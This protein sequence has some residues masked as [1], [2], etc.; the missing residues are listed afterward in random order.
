MS[1]EELIA[2]GK[3]LAG[4][5]A[6]S[7][8][9]FPVGASRVFDA[10]PEIDYY[11]DA[12]PVFDEPPDEPDW[13]E[14][15]R[16]PDPLP[17][18]ADAVLTRSALRTLPD[19]EPLILD[20]LDL[21][22][23]ALL[24]GRWGCAKT[25]IA[26]DWAASV[27]TGR[28]WQNRPTT[29]RRVLYVVGEAAFGFKGRLDAWEVG[30]QTK[31][32]DGQLD[33]LPR[34]VNLTNPVDVGNLAALIDWGG[35]GFIVVDTLSRCMVGADENSARDTGLVVDAMSRL[36]ART[37]GGRGVLLGVHHAGKDGKTLRGSSV[38]EAAA[39][40]VYFASRDGDTVTLDREKRKDGPE[41]DR[42]TLQLDLIPGTGSATI[43]AGTERGTTSRA[44]DLSSIY[45]HNFGGT[46]CT[47]AQLRDVTDWPRTT[48]Y[49]A[50]SELVESGELVNTGTG[51]RP[52]YV[53]PGDE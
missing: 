23:V 49:R 38:F 40:T 3:A 20:T 26:L 50:L 43:G 39:D 51:Q 22:T 2:R 28:R 13:S 12:P 44:K 48:F 1:N 34:A 8:G 32:S 47:G 37:P 31:I 41:H 6:P 45:S 19:P 11:R 7:R 42:H 15:G 30:W 9:A 24:Y 10:P 5:Y 18:Y 36:L 17:V 53:R 52:F 25:F 29:A 33:I 21:G 4:K 27:A 35:Y 16:G 14:E 46:G